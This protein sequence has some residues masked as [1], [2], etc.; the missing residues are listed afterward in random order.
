MPYIRKSRA[1]SDSFGN[2]WP[3][4]GA[5]AEVPVHQ[6]T[7]LLSIP[8]GGFAE[9]APPAAADPEDDP[10][11]RFSEVASDA[12]V[13]EAPKRRGRPPKSVAASLIEE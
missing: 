7:A 11:S 10:E 1:G 9:V 12:P 2:E 4:D 3:V 5:V 13:S 8:D 6:A